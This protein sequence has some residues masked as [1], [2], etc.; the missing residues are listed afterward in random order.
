V[1]AIDEDVSHRFASKRAVP[2]LL[3]F[4]ALV[5]RLLFVTLVHQP[6][7]HVVSDMWVFDLRAKHLVSGELGPWDSFTPAGYPAFLSCFYATVGR[8]LT[9]IGIVQALL[10]ALTV[11]LT[12]LL[13]VEISKDRKIGSLAA[14][15]IALHVPTVLYS[16][17]LLSETLFSFLIVLA[18]YL[19]LR[20]VSKASL[21]LAGWVGLVLGIAAVVRPPLLLALPWVPVFFFFALG[22][23]AG[24]VAGYSA[25]VLAIA[26]VPLAAHS[27]HNSRLVDRWVPTST[28]GGL[29]FYLNFA[30]VRSVKFKEGS[31]THQITPIPN[32]IRY[33]RDEPVER[34]FYD[35]R[36]FYAEGLRLLADRPLRVLKGFWSLKETLGFGRQEYWPGWPPWRTLLGAES[37]VFALL[38]VLPGFFGLGL[39]V[40]GGTPFRPEGAGWLWIGG[41]LAASLVAAAAYLGDPRIRVPYDPFYAIGAGFA[42]MELARW[43]RTRRL[44]EK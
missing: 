17:L 28:N 31:Y 13:A 33:D 40:K 23:S 41:L 22:R 6:G 42:Y 18:S 11:V 10:S 16:G 39:L 34:P 20:A 19:L 12:Y 38:F 43:L 44:A 26:L 15:A 29:N 21:A 25:V 5:P 36:Y 9:L 2:W 24:R 4:A 7:D 3:F 37:R 30:E 1:T 8:E 27:W 14:I 35:D 32:L